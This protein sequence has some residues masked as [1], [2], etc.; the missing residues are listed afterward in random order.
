MKGMN[1]TDP[2]TLAALAA[3]RRL[4]HEARED[5]VILRH[6]VAALADATDWRARSADGYRAG[7]AL[8]SGDLDALLRVIDGFDAD[9]ADLPRGGTS[10]ALGGW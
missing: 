3:A 5:A 8:L 4:L 1:A 6:R 9:L 2:A 10:F 7:I